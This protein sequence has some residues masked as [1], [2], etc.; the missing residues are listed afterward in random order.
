MSIL[1]VIGRFQKNVEI[2]S[3]KGLSVHGSSILTVKDR[4]TL[5]IKRIFGIKSCVFCCKKQAFL[6]D[7]RDLLFLSA[8]LDF[9]ICRSQAFS[10][11]SNNAWTFLAIVI[12][13]VL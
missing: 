3:E 7:R 12:L 13:E 11:I 8:I 2:M 1:S 5:T 6:R 10:A 9:E 4:L